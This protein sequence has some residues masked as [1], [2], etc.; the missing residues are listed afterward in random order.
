MR[1]NV[2]KFIRTSLIALSGLA[3]SL[4]CGQ[5]PAASASSSGDAAKGKKLFI[6]VGCYYCHGQDGHRAGQAGKLAPK[7]V[8]LAVGI[9]YVRKPGGQMIAYSP[10]VLSDA[11]LTDIWAYLRSLPE[12]PSPD[13][14]PI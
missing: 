12:D 4:A 8:P 2:K 9:A 5:S 7:P 6:D 1:G 3:G 11:D 13:S 14:I 10:K